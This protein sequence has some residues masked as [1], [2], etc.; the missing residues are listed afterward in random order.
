M[1]E[2]P[3]VETI[4]NQIA[5]HLPVKV[6]SVEYSDVSSS[7]IKDQEFNPKGREFTSIERRGKVLLLNF[8]KGLVAISGLGMS[9]GWRVSPKKISEKHTHIQLSCKKENGDKIYFGYVDPRRFGNIHFFKS[10]GAKKWLTRLGADVSKAEFTADYIYSRCQKHPGK[11]IKAFLLEQNHFAG[12]GNY[13]ASEICAHAGILPDRL[14][15]NISQKDAQKLLEA[16][17]IV[18][19]GT[20]SSGGTTF[21]G[22]Y[23]DTTGSQGEGVKNLVV[24]YQEVCRMCG[25][26]KVLKTILKGRGTYHCPRCQK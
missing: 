7:I 26:T 10:I 24:F 22:G 13:M 23:K 25:R 9:G 14:N 18:L 15:K 1:P 16:T 12:V 2:L 19:E 11:A 3:E 17:A 4:K 5:P 6:T 21:S 8:E 20:V